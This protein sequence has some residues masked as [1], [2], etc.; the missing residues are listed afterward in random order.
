MLP[1]A[2][3]LFH[4]SCRPVSMFVSL[5]RL[6]CSLSSSLPLIFQNCT[7]HHTTAQSPTPHH[8]LNTLHPHTTHFS[9]HHTQHDKPH[10]IHITPTHHFVHHTT[11]CHHLTHPTASPPSHPIPP[12]PTIHLTSLTPPHFTSTHV[13]SPHLTPPYLTPTHAMFLLFLLFVLKIVFFFAPQSHPIALYTTAPV[14]N[15]PHHVWVGSG[16]CDPDGSVGGV[17][18]QVVLVVL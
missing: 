12:N 18:A 8:P 13:N 11:P 9:R 7:P 3:C 17:I 5:L 6:E 10:T 4:R 16:C 1:S 2:S 15:A 14:L